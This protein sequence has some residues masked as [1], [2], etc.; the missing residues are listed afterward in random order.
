[1]ALQS[2]QPSIAD[3]VVAGELVLDRKHQTARRGQKALNL[4]LAPFRMLEFLMSNPGKV[5]TRRQLAHALWGYDT[6]VDERT[7]DVE[8]GRIRGAMN[9]GSD[10]DPIR[11]V[12]G[13]GYAFDETFGFRSSEA[14]RKVHRRRSLPSPR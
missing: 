1:L 10:A 5:F 11:T 4:S 3:I 13:D 9:R 14:S 2:H 8:V 12:R 7:V 6:N